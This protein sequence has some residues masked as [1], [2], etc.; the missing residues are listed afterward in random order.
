MDAL[1]DELI[2][3]KRS[4]FTRFDVVDQVVMR[5]C[6]LFENHD[7]T[8]SLIAQA[9]ALHEALG[10]LPLDRNWK[11]GISPELRGK[12]AAAHGSPTN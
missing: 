9:W 11:R 3:G 12:L 4:P 10:K 7:Q 8:E 5:L 6:V 2:K 1:V